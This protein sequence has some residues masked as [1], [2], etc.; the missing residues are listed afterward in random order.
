MI[1]QE[2][3]SYIPTD[4]GVLAQQIGTVAAKKLSVKIMQMLADPLLI[5]T[6]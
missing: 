2:Q 3:V 1:A 4:G 6:F 5:V